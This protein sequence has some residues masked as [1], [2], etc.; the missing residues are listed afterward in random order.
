MQIDRVTSDIDV[1]A[2]LS[3]LLCRIPLRSAE[4][5][6]EVI[7]RTPWVCCEILGKW[8]LGIVPIVTRMLSASGA[9][10]TSLSLK[11]FCIT[12]QDLSTVLQGFPH[13]ESLTLGGCADALHKK[14]GGE[15]TLQNVTMLD[16]SD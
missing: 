3:T 4:P 6:A 10:L 15:V 8:D 7:S 12:G 13:L 9:S 16:V 14:G 1:R 5:F 2:N 11:A